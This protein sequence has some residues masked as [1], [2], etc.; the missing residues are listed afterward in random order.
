MI[1][2]FWMLKSA[3]FVVFKTNFFASLWLCVGH[4][5][6]W[7]VT[8]RGIPSRNL[9]VFS[10]VV[11]TLG[12]VGLYDNAFLKAYNGNFCHFRKCLCKPM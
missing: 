7:W 12:I 11:L 2:V 1:S 3:L 5:G 9:G 10:L 4:L 8:L 6:Y